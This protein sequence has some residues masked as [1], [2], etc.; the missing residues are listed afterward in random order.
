MGFT[1]LNVTL[2]LRREWKPVLASKK[3][4]NSLWE[5]EIYWK[6]NTDESFENIV[7][8][9]KIGVNVLKLIDFYVLPRS[10]NIKIVFFFRADMLA[11][12]FPLLIL[13]IFWIISATL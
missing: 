11:F 7:G 4:K 8:F 1:Q 2:P 9:Y 12:P 13:N 10:K 3:K 5:K 6:Y